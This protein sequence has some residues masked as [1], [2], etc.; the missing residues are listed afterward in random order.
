[1]E[2]KEWEKFK[3][4][5]SDHAEWQA[6][7]AEQSFALWAFTKNKIS[8]EQYREW[9]VQ[10]Y[11]VPFVKDSFFYSISINQEFWNR[12]KEREQWSETFLPLY[13]WESLVFAGCVAPPKNIR[14]KN[15]VPLLVE[16]KNLSS[17]WNKI[18]Q[19]SQAREESEPEEQTKTRNTLSEQENK[20]GFFSKLNLL[21]TGVNKTAL[22]QL[23][24]SDS[25]T[26]Y[27]QVFKLSEKYF[28]GVI[29]FSFQKNEF[30]PHKW[31]D[32][33]PAL[34]AP[35][36]TDKPSMFKMII[37]SRSPY[38]GFV[39]NNETHRDFFKLWGFETLPKHITLVPIFNDSKMIVGA[40][41][42]IAEQTVHQKSLYE[43]TKWVKPFAKILQS[44]DKK[45]KSA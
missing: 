6:S 23:K 33:L 19:L 21:N 26:L 34:E 16:P 8:S 36:N 17:F 20:S 38:H 41:M 29:I 7:S 1:M 12:V 13:E 3:L 9:A 28:T 2:K 22:T 40:Y 5:E 42:G 35:A 37:T 4:S 45:S 43:I 32:S 31:S 44:K 24:A 39:V 18:Q 15:T 30:K 27:E 11:K 14:D 10:N 25:S